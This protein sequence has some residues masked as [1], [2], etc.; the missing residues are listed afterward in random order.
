MAPAS[1]P[2]AAEKRPRT[3]AAEE[4]EKEEEEEAAAAAPPF[5]VVKKTKAEYD[6]TLAKLGVAKVCEKKY[7]R[8]G[9]EEPFTMCET[10]NLGGHNMC[11]QCRKDRKG[12][13]PRSSHGKL[14]RGGCP[15]AGLPG[16]EGRSRT[17]VTKTFKDETV[18]GSYCKA[19]CAAAA[20]KAIYRHKHEGVLYPE[21]FRPPPS[22][23][24]QST[25]AKQK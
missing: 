18:T 13:A 19:S 9:S 10:V 20:A 2:A 12:K 21:G 5:E 17:R 22:T 11:D 8:T 4:S 6:A 23:S 25:A 24:S 15:G 3:G 14:G 16:C 7:R 1:E